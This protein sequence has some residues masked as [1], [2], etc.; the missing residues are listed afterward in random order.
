M[1]RTVIEKCK[2]YNWMLSNRST[3][4]NGAYHVSWRE[5]TNTVI[6]IISAKN[7]GY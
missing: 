7:M 3:I 4:R 6:T 2:S 1:R 5:H